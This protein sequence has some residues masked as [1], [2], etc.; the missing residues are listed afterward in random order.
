MAAQA[1]GTVRNDRG[2]DALIGMTRSQ[3]STDRR[4][5]AVN[6]RSY[7][8]DDRASQRLVELIRD[9]DVSVAYTAIDAVSSTPD[10]TSALSSVVRN[11]GMSYQL[12]MRAANALRGTSR[13]D[14]STK[15]MIESFENSVPA[16][17]NYNSYSRDYE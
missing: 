5:A 4:M 2:R 14:P 17:E 12:R 15:A 13:L 3:D 8:H 7:E 11:A 6:L 9:P 1:L 16:E 10:A